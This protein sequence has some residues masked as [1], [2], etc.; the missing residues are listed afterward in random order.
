MLLGEVPYTQHMPHFL[1]LY[2]WGQN[3]QKFEGRE[4]TS[5]DPWAIFTTLHFL[6]N[7]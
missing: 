7:L 5:E 4:N 1:N 6:L 2:L 3:S